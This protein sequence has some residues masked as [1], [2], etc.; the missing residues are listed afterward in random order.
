[1][2]STIGIA[3]ANCAAV[4]LESCCEN[5]H[6]AYRVSFS[7]LQHNRQAQIPTNITWVLFTDKITWPYKLVISH[8]NPTSSGCQTLE[9]R[10]EF[11]SMAI[12]KRAIGVLLGA[13]FLLTSQV[14][15]QS[16]QDQI[17]AT[18][19]D[20][21]GVDFT[22]QDEAATHAMGPLM[23]D[24][25][26]RLFQ[27]FEKTKTKECRAKI[28]EHYGYFTK[29]FGLEKPLPFSEMGL[30]NNTCIDEHPWDFNNLPKGVVSRTDILYW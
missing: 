21:S 5:R 29:A 4:S 15:G 17:T 27:L 30:F 19:V 7:N 6:M 20:L 23:E 10:P 18:R 24:L 26:R 14:I 22:D 11:T 13:I 9:F 8:T 12:M 3:E 2:Q 16:R 1:M 28:A 25:D